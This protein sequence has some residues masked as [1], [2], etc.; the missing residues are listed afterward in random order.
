[1][2][3]AELKAAF[4]RNKTT[5]G[6]AGAA[7]V[8]GLA[9]LQARK[10]S[11]GAAAGGDTSMSA[12][13]DSVLSAPAAGYAYDSS[14]S[15]AYNAL[16]PQIERLERL[17]EGIDEKTK[18]PIPVATPPKPAAPKPAAPKP[19]A[20]KSPLA[21]VKNGFYKI[22]GNRYNIYQV[23]NGRL[24]YLTRAEFDSITR[25]KKVSVT[26]VAKDNPMWQ[27]GSHW[28]DPS[29]QKPATKK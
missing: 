22:A 17:F 13:G 19:A 27:S 6:V 2:N 1:M 24:D 11:G 7:V 9:L 20:P 29:K 25:G 21:S 4:E 23:S 8:G 5:L 12:G 15:D 10:S 3:G 26:S 28:L 14:N 16:Q 18:A